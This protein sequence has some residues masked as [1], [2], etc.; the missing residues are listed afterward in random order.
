MIFGQRPIKPKSRNRSTGRGIAL[1][2]EQPLAKLADP[3]VSKSWSL[4]KADNYSIFAKNGV[5]QHNRLLAAIL[6][7]LHKWSLD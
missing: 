4:F 1:A 5:F 7:D 2:Q 6:C 3:L